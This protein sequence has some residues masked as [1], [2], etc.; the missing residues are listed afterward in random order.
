MALAGP[1][2]T[3]FWSDEE[4]I[5]LIHQLRESDIL[6]YLDGRK[7]RNGKVFEKVANAMKNAGFRRSPEQIR[8]RWKRLKQVYYNTKKDAASGHKPVWC[9][10]FQLLDDL[11]GGHPRS[12]SLDV[13]VGLLLQ[14][15]VPDDQGDPNNDPEAH[16]DKDSDLKS[17]ESVGSSYLTHPPSFAPAS[18]LFPQRSPGPGTFALLGQRQRPRGRRSAFERF[19]S[20]MERMQSV[21]AEQFQ[22]CQERQERLVDSI[23]QSNESMVSA[24][25]EGLQ[26]LRPHPAD[27]R[28]EKDVRQ[29]IGR[30]HIKEEDLTQEGGPKEAELTESPPTGVS[31]KTED[32]PPESSQLGH[33][34]REETGGAEPPSSSS[35]SLGH[36]PEADGG[37][38]NLLAP[39]SDCDDSTSHFSEDD[40][41]REPLS[42]DTD[43]DAIP[44]LTL[45]TNAP[46]GRPV[47]T[48]RRARFVLKDFLTGVFWLS[49]C[50]RTQGRNPFVCA[51]CDKRF[52]AKHNMMS[53]MKTHT[54]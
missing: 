31:G 11:L 37:A 44:G 50:E 13:G 15:G 14:K 46:Q 2:G 54:P 45:T 29:L 23:L 28:G 27:H 52:T 17:N 1:R 16:P 4:T 53:H 3:H 36:T 6:K 26:S 34:P 47:K 7:T 9:P 49:T 43:D 48:R 20:S 35:S 18:T 42:S 19:T 40:D 12:R 25:L 24:L 41:A 30:P 32:K 8:V 51:V 33:G 39:L 22:R 38:D 10:H 5:F 21:L